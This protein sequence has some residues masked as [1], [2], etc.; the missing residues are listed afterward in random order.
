M[1]TNK[2]PK[3]ASR[4]IRY[5]QAYGS[6]TSK[7]AMEDLGVYRLASRINELKRDGYKIDRKMIKVRGRD[8]EA[9]YVAQYSLAEAQ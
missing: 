9:C 5:M 2:R 4:I 6:I 1:E 3:Q 7:Q 8:G